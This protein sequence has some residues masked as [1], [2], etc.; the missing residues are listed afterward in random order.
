[1]LHLLSLRNRSIQTNRVRRRFTRAEVSPTPTRPALD[2]RE[3]INSRNQFQTGLA[4]FAGAASAQ[5]NSEASR[6][7][8][9][10]ELFAD[11]NS[12]Q[13]ST[14]L[15]VSQHRAQHQAQ[16]AA[17]AKPA[18]STVSRNDLGTIKLAHFYGLWQGPMP[19][20]AR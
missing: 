14:G 8:R 6:Q 1:M 5:R 17:G 10:E 4:N 20:L 15:T 12:R 9:F 11:L 3:R 19:K 16:V 2:L 7:Q 13:L 18:A